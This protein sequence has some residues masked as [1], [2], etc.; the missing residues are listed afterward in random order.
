MLQ[1]VF[2]WHPKTYLPLPVAK[3]ANLRDLVCLIWPHREYSYKMC[4]IGSKSALYGTWKKFSTLA[5][6]G[7]RRVL[8]IIVQPHYY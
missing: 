8:L 7:L 5:V 1:V 6:P 2:L 3:G 4:H